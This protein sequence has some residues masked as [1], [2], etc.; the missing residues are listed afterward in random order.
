MDRSSLPTPF[1]WA[2]SWL[3]KVD[4]SHGSW[5][6]PKDSMS[7][8]RYIMRTLCQT[9]C[10]ASSQVLPAGQPHVYKARRTGQVDQPTGST[11]TNLRPMW[12]RKTVSWYSCLSDWCGRGISMT[13]SQA[14]Q[15]EAGVALEK[16]AS[17]KPI[18]GVAVK[19]TGARLAAA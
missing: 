13:A 2:S 7:R 9:R 17:G 6:R 15:L 12:L 16:A 1:V 8:R 10:A 11:Y 14:Y 4:L 5:R 18:A 3:Q 19:T